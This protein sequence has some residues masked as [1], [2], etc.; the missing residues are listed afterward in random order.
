MT[1]APLLAKSVAVIFPMPVLA[2][3]KKKYR[4]LKHSFEYDLL[5]DCY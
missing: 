2:P 3:V 5:A 1:L 4:A